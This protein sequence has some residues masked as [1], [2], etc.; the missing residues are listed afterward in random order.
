MVVEVR[1][2]VPPPP[3]LFSSF[4]VGEFCVCSVCVC[5]FRHRA[6]YMIQSQV[7]AG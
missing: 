7:Y 3:L 2:E 1:K 4:H 5:L 6:I